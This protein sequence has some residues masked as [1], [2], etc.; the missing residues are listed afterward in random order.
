MALIDFTHLKVN[1]LEEVRN[2]A[3]YL[4]I[5][6]WFLV[7]MVGDMITEALPTYENWLMEVEGVD[8]LE[9]NG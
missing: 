8:N 2:Y 5:Y 1:F 3:K 4:R 6:L 7:A 9:R